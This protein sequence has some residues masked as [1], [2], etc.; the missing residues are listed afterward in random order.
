MNISEYRGVMVFAEQRRGEIQKVAFELLGAGRGIADTLQEPL[1]A[2]LAGTYLTDAQAASLIAHGA[3]RVILVD[4]PRLGV[5]MTE[6][7]T[8]ALTA[9]ITAEKPGR[10][11]EHTSELQSH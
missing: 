8:K 11:E 5:Y 1:I 7:F 4:D 2:V 10:S 9:V 3:D 6:P